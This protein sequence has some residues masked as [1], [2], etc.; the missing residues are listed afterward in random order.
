[1]WTVGDAMGEWRVGNADGAW[2]QPRANGSGFGEDEKV[3]GSR[4]F[5]SHALNKWLYRKW[6]AC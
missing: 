2:D 1:M 6:V 4:G 3:G 5:I